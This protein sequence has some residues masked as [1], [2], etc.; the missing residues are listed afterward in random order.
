MSGPYEL[1]VKGVYGSMRKLYQR[2]RIWNRARRYRWRD[3]PDEC[4][5]ACEA[6]RSGDVALD[7]GA[8][9]AAFTWWMSRQVGRNGRVHAFEPQPDLASY[10]K[11]FASASSYQ[12]VVV[13]ELALA[14][15][16]GVAEFLV[17]HTHRGWGR[18]RT[19]TDAEDAGRWIRVNVETLDQ[20]LNPETA[21]RPIAFIK[22][23]V[24]L[25]ELAVFQGAAQILSIDRP[26]LLFESHP[27]TRVAS[28]ENRTFSFLESFGYRGYFF[29]E[30]E[31]LPLE[32]YWGA[33]HHLTN[34]E[35]QNYV[36]LLPATVTLVQG[37]PPY[38]LQRY[39]DRGTSRLA[40]V[41]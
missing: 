31:L 2:L 24:E 27:L 41:A 19:Q 17:P 11:T 3:E 8:H 14:D 7:I 6:L 26:I 37:R 16:Q 1:R 34:D 12:N 30:Q 18:L 22:C 20:V 38:Q 35:V 13:H 21:P 4:R 39:T 10:L 32:K 29:Y 40:R 36:F 23:D 15:H 9:K 25:H 28:T 33:R 5:F